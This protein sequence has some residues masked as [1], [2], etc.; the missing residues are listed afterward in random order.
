MKRCVSFEG[1]PNATV[2]EI[3]QETGFLKGMIPF[4]YL[5]VPMDSKKLTVD[6]CLPAFNRKFC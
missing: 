6:K 2:T 5:G 3:L 1:V 4:K